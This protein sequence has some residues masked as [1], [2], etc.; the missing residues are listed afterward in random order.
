MIERHCG[1]HYT[2]FLN[3]LQKKL[4]A[5]SYLEIGVANGGSLA[6]VE[7]ATAIGVDVSFEFTVNVMRGKKNL[8]LFQTSSDS[9]FREEAAKKLVPDGVDFAFLDGMHAFE[10]LLRD[11]YNTEKVCNRR[12]VIAMHDCL[13]VNF[14]MTERLYVPSART[15]QDYAG[16]WTGDVWKIIPILEKYRPDLVVVPVDCAPTGLVLV[17]N[18]DPQSR[19]IEDRYLSIVREFGP[20]AAD[21]QEL[22]ALYARIDVA[23]ANRIIEGHDHTLFFR[24]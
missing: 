8:H 16:W 13:P 22:D 23:D 10:F 24:I 21:S 6:E 1:A 20:S 2:H 18:L 19:V 11:F 12:S 5:R 9:F 7:C 4:E 3:V 14:E 15:D 17:T